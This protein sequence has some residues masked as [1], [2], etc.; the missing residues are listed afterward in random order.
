MEQHLHHSHRQ[1]GRRGGVKIL[2]L[3]TRR[4]FTVYVT[5]VIK[6]DSLLL[7]SAA[8]LARGA[9]FRRGGSAT[10]EQQSPKTEKKISQMFLHSNSNDRF[11]RRKFP[12]PEKILGPVDIRPSETNAVHFS[13]PGVEFSVK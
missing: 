8:T 9:H 1:A 6:R 10:K 7:S 13:R 2:V 3:Y 4:V 11:E 5:G 12:I